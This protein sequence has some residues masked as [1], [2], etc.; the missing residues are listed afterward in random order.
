MP[1]IKRFSGFKEFVRFNSEFL[2]S[3]PMLC[4]FLIE[5]INRVLDG[6][7]K[8]HKFFNIL[9][10]NNRKVVLLT[11]EVCLVYDDRF[12]KEIIPLLSEELEFAKFI[13]YQFSGCKKTIDALFQVNQARY[14]MQNIGSFTNAR[15][16][17]KILG[18]RQ[19]VC[20]WEIS[21]ESKN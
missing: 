10:G 5:T 4:F 11:T 14:D 15:P 16:F 18:M 9:N 21:I 19:V 12:D 17:H 20:K 7:E 1:Q 8:V 2:D 13:L 6:E 3:N